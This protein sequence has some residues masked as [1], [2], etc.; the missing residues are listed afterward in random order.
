MRNNI[1]DQLKQKEKCYQIS[2]D[3]AFRPIENL[4]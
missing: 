2:T 3:A 1:Q 4:S